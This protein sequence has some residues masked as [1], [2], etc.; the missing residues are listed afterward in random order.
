[1]DQ[2]SLFDTQSEHSLSPATAPLADRLRPQGLEDYIGQTHL[3]GPGMLLRR[4]LEQ[5]QIPSMIFWGP[6]GVGKTT[7]AKIIAG[8]TKSDFVNFSAVT[9]G[10][11]EIKDIMKQAEDNRAFGVRTLV[12]VDEIHRF[13]KAQQDAFLPYVERGSIT[14]I[15]ATTENPS[16]EIN[17]ALLSRCKVFVL[18]ELTE[19]DLCRLL[20]R[21]LTD[22][23]GF[24]NMDVRIDGELLSVIASFANGDARTALNTLEM[25]VLN[26]EISPDGSITVKK[27]TLEQCLGK[28]TLLYDK[29]GEEHYNLI[30]ALHKSMRNS[31]PDAAVYWLARM[32]EAGEDP[33]FI[34]RRLIRFASEDIGLADSQALPL[35]VAA[36][37]ACHFNGMPECDLNL[38]Q[39]VI[40]LS[41][42]PRSNA[43]YR[44]Y[45]TAKTD[46]LAQLAEPVPLVIRNAPTRLM[47][48][49]HYGEGYTYAHDTEEKIA[50]MTCL[51]E[52]LKN[53]QYYLPTEEGAEGT[54]KERLERSRSFRQG[55]PS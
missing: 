26:G 10:I 23:K 40:Y 17:A 14:L 30:S 25:A 52:S 22:K 49:L 28:K 55:E 15:G 53:R 29:K 24:G 5:D 36:Y 9:S 54:F 46:A 39:T 13:N 34:A 12:F 43:V 16:F 21:A 45:E 7:L 6:P 38:A 2:L 50:A 19:E 48:D 47:S 20:S 8:R 37:Q 31:D 11:R 27:E 42:A 18:K 32:L 51:P 35:A 4:M 1:M 33:L 3:L 44:A 41:L